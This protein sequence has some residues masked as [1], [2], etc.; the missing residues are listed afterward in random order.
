MENSD[1]NNNKEIKPLVMIIIEEDG[2]TSWITTGKIT[3]RQFNLIQKLV[4]VAND[5]SY[6]LLAAI[7]LEMIV[8]GIENIISSTFKAF[9]K[10]FKDKFTK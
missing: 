10:I 3:E 7:Y 5:P 2:N 6:F 9:I 4:L 8:N 1:L